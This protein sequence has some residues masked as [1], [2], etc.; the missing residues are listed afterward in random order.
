MLVLIRRPNMGN[1]LKDKATKAA[2][3]VAVDLAFKRIKKDPAEG[4]KDVI[5]VIDKY[6]MP[7][8]YEENSAKQAITRIRE[9][10]A[11]PNSKWVSF[12]E[13]IVNEIDDNIIKRFVMTFGYNA[14]YKGNALRN[15]LQKKYN[16]NIPWAIL[17]DPTSACNLKCKG[18]WAAEYGNKNNLTYEEMASIVRQGN[19]LGTYFFIMTGGEPL[20]RKD[21]I[22]KL[23]NE[24]N[25]SAFHI[26]TNGTLIDDKFCEEVAKAGNISF[27]LSIEGTEESTD[28]RRGD[29]VYKRVIEA[30]DLMKKHKLLYGVSV[31]YTSQNYKQVTS[32]EFMYNLIDHGC[33]LAWYFHYMPVGNDAEPSLLP[34]P[35]QRK[36]VFHKVREIR[37]GSSPMNI[38]TIDFQNDGEF[39]NGCI[40]G[41]RNYFHI[42]S[43]GDMEPC[44]FIHFSDSNIREKTILEGLQSP[45]FMGFHD[46]QP[47]NDNMLK[48]CPMLENP[49]RLTKLVEDSKSKS[50]DLISPESPENLEEKCIPYA[51]DWNKTADS[52]WKERQENKKEKAN[53]K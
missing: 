31:C 53:I 27:A 11:N 39:I 35:E 28:F 40:A 25:E 37:S 51:K 23:A 18:C 14:V 48:P 13:D 17:F 1:N 9:K 2:F 29:G 38:F 34:N 21:D 52:I 4:M 10:F 19:E 12:G 20:V 26:F 6:L 3:S 50:T 30:M 43:L 49:G 46:N 7:E 24:F 15:E 16:C 5:D 33:K 8:S 47:F 22:I 45:L 42:N 41:G 44:V 36:Y 32:D